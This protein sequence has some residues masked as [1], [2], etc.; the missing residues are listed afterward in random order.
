MSRRYAVITGASSGVG[1]ALCAALASPDWHLHLLGRDAKRLRDVERLVRERGATATLDGAD[2]AS[3]SALTDVPL[4][5]AARLPSIHL[6]VHCAGLFA[7]ESISDAAEGDFQRLVQVNLIAP[8]A[9]T[10]ALLPLLA[11]GDCDVVMINSSAVGRRQAGLSAYVASKQGL[12]GMT[13]SVR[14]DL[15]PRQIRVLSVFLGA[16]ATPMQQSIH[17]SAGRR[18]EAASLLDPDHVAQAILAAITL[19]RAA[20]LTDLH[21]RPAQPQRGSSG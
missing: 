2:F 16:T 18:Y 5:V 15:G 13:E 20:E 19:P 3:Q 12:L 8:Y 4:N 7:R 9:L 1:R 10:R 14:Q 11:D 6:L 21:L 17:E